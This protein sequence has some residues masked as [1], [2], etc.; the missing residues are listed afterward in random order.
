MQ[1]KVLIISLTNANNILKGI[2]KTLNGATSP[3]LV[4][5]ILGDDGAEGYYELLAM[6]A[7]A[8]NSPEFPVVPAK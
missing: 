4:K 7:R 1:E 8:E 2:Q 5:H 6:I 3:E